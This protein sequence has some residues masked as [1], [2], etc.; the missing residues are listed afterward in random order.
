MNFFQAQTFFKRMYPNKE[1][2]FEFD[3]KCLGRVELEYT[4]GELNPIHHVENNKLKVTVFD[5]DAIYVDIAPHRQNFT[6]EALEAHAQI[7]LS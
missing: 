1:I 4:D 2:Q 5:M 7:K 6:T 3:E